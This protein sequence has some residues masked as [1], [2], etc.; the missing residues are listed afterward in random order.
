MVNNADVGVRYDGIFQAV[1]YLFKRSAMQ[2]AHIASIEQEL[3]L[4]R[5]HSIHFL[6][7]R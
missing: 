2:R 6:P 4:H 3:Y 7:L 1:Q 5:T